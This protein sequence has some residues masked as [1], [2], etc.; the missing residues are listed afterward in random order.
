MR[1]LKQPYGDEDLRPPANNQNQLA[2]HVSDSHRSNQGSIVFLN[3]LP[4]ETATSIERELSLKKPTAQG[5]VFLFDKQLALQENT[6][7]EESLIKQPLAWHEKPRI[8]KETILRVSLALQENP[9]IEEGAILKEPW[10]LQENP[11]IEEEAILKEPLALQEKPSSEMEALFKEPLAFQEM[12][13]I[14]EALNFKEIFALNEKSTPGKEL[15]FKEPLALP[16]NPTHKEDT[17]LKDFLILQV[18]TSPHVSST[19]PESRTGMSS[20]AAMS[21]VGKLST[22]SKSSACESSSNKPFS[23]QGKRSQ[24]EIIPLEDIDKDHNDP[25]FNSIYAND[26]FNY[27]KE[28]EEK[29]ILKKY[30]NRQTD[31]SSDMRAILVDWLVE[32]QSPGH[33]TV[34]VAAVAKSGR[35]RKLAEAE[36]PKGNNLPLCSMDLQL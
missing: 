14:N 20:T 34:A 22:T 26:I 8:E 23:S 36:T 21:S 24:K 28:R 35:E 4:T 31:I 5:E 1:T 27:M 25:F 32:V 9:T 3:E 13:T 16:E 6:N 15:S 17:F 10:G 30:M 7:E 29:F 11:I 18:E 2:C 33:P 12:P 19:A